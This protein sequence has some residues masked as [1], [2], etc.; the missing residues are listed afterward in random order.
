MLSHVGTGDRKGRERHDRRAGHEEPCVRQDPIPARLPTGAVREFDVREAR[1]PCRAP[2][3]RKQK[4]GRRGGQKRDE[5][6]R[7]SHAHRY[8]P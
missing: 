2:K 5:G 4:K 3:A 7:L 6:Q 8:H 1:P